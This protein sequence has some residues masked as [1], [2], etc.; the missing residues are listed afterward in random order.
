MIAGVMDIE[1]Q[2]LPM[3]ST[4]ISD[5]ENSDPNGG[6]VHLA[7]KEER[8]SAESVAGVDAEK[9]E[10]IDLNSG[11]EKTDSLSNAGI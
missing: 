1:S 4:A 8:A 5:H 3:S 9:L 11:E 10:G 6:D 7:S 2:I